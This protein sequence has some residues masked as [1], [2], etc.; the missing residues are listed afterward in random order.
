MR[1][2][3]RHPADIPIEVS[4]G[5]QLAHATRHTYNVSFGGLAFQSDSELEP[6]IVVNVRIP[7]VRPMFETKA[8]V[9]WC[10]AH[11]GGFE[12]GVEFLDPEDAFRARMVEQVCYIENYKKAVYR[13]EGRLLTAE[14]AA[15]EWIRKYASRFPDTGPNGLN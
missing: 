15:M 6:G 1:Q 11:E 14:E 7:F 8:R 10:G 3:I 13:T 5:D 2:F 12:L 9:V 4:A